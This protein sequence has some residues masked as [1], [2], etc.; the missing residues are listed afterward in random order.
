MHIKTHETEEKEKVKGM[1]SKAME[2]LKSMNATHKEEK[3]SLDL[4]IN[5]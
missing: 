3:A 2:K 1:L 4:S 5:K